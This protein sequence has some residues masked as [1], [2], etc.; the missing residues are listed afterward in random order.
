MPAVFPSAADTE[1]KFYLQVLGISGVG[2][3][4][5]DLRNQF[6]TGVNNGTIMLGGGG[7]AVRKV[8]PIK[9]VS[10]AW[11]FAT[12]AAAQTAG[13]GPDDIVLLVGNPG[14]TP[15]AWMRDFDVWVQ[16]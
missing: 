2:M 13:L 1:R 8:F 3:T 4:I 7:S 6:Y 9:Y 10:G 12:L 15:T 5:G 11:E 14:G 16:G